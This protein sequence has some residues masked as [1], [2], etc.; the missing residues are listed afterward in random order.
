MKNVFTFAASILFVDPEDL[1][2]HG[3][4]L[5]RL[6]YAAALAAMFGLS[7]LSENM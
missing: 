2:Y 7:C 4:S 1:R 3:R 6:W 5:Q